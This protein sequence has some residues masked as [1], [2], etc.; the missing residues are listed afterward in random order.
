M[1]WRFGQTDGRLCGLDNATTLSGKFESSLIVRTEHGK[2]RYDDWHCFWW[3]SVEN[4]V[5]RE[6]ERE[7]CAQILQ[8]DRKKKLNQLEEI[9]WQLKFQDEALTR[10]TDGEHASDSAESTDHHTYEEDGREKNDGFKFLFLLINEW[11]TRSGN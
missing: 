7:A 4:G 2:V 5:S 9:G 10:Q 3:H 1:S 11:R 8:V 6:R